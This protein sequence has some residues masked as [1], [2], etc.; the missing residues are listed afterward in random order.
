ML[1]VKNFGYFGRNKDELSFLKKFTKENECIFIVERKN[2][3][4]NY[5]AKYLRSLGIKVF[6]GIPHSTPHSTIV[7][8][9]TVILMYYA[10]EDLVDYHT[11]V[12]N[13]IKNLTSLK[14]IKMFTNI[15]DDNRFQI[16]VV[17][18]H[19]AEIADLTRKHLLK[20]VKKCRK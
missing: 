17:F 19:D 2:I 7:C 10:G 1:H 16:S 8:G 14:A 12:H 5:I 4:N 11:K 13:K 18:N 3:I 15:R 20:F 6:I 9:D